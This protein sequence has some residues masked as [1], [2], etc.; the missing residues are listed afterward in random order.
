LDWIRTVN[1]LKLQEPD[2]TAIGQP[3]FGLKSPAARAGELFKPST[4]LASLVH[5]IEKKTIFGFSGRFSR[6][7]V[8]KKTRFGNFGHLWPA[9]DL[10]LLS[11]LLVQSFVEN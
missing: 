10:N 8:T 6:G 2:Q 5:K 1:Y 9:L 7:D 3:F 11:I 4:D